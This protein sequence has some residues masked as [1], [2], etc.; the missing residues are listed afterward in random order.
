VATP[1]ASVAGEG[2]SQDEGKDAGE[3]F[4]DDFSDGYAEDY[5]IWPPVAKHEPGD[6]RKFYTVVQSNV[7]GYTFTSGAAQLVPEVEV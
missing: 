3:E 4:E 7:L 6:F 1:P 5:Y 2:G